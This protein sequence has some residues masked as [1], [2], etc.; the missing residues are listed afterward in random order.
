MSDPNTVDLVLKCVVDAIAAIAALGTA[1][2]GL[3]DVTKTLPRR[4]NVS[5]R[6]GET[7]EKA[8]TPF[9][10]AM[11]NV[12]GAGWK[13][14]I[15]GPWI[16]GAPRDEQKNTAKSTIRLGLTKDN[17]AAIAKAAHVA[18]AALDTAIGNLEAGAPLA[19]A[20]INVLG[21][22]DATVDAILAA[23]YERAD[24]QY[25]NTAKFVAGVFAIGLALAGNAILDKAHAPQNWVVAVLVG[26]VAVP[27]APMAKDLTTALQTAVKTIGS[28]SLKKPG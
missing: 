14:A 12:L 16:N 17:S 18:P 9:A 27:L 23:A 4:L 1:A 11:E 15:M 22:L 26:I 19:T 28:I 13:D 24:Q 10:K 8:L 25:R 5:Y 6:G 21:R 20:D 3:V 2:S 7:I